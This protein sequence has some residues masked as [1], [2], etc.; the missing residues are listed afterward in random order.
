MRD[1]IFSL[2]TISRMKKVPG[3]NLNLFEMCVCT[4]TGSVFVSFLLLLLFFSCFSLSLKFQRYFK[5]GVDAWN[6]GDRGRRIRRSVS[7]TKQ[8]I[9]LRSFMNSPKQC[10][11]LLTYFTKHTALSVGEVG[12]D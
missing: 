7:K 3:R 8:N 4:L 10:Y 12:R 9:I 2:C 6:L 1:K 11:F 5:L